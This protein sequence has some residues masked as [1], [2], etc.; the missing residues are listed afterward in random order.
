MAGHALILVENLSVP[1][2]RRVWQECLALREAGWRGHVICPQGDQAGHRALRRDRRR[3]DP[4]L[5]AH[6][7]PSAGRSGTSGSTPPRCGT[8][9]GWPAKVGRVDVVHACNP[10]DL[11]YLVAKQL[12]RRGARF[13]FDQHDLVPELYLSRFDRGKDLL[14]R[15]GLPDGAQDLRGGRR[16][17]RDQR[18]ATGRPRS[19]AVASARR[20]SSWSAARRSWSGSARCR[21]TR[22]CGRGK[23]YLL[24]LPRASWV[25][26]DG[27]DY[28]LRAL[29]KLRDEVGRSDWHAVFIGGGD[30][31][32][33]HGRALAASWACPTRWSSPAGSRTRT[34]CGICPPRT[35]A[36]RPIRSTRSTTCRP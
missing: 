10:P 7:R 24:C 21:R 3:P 25:P 26:Q 5:P 17:H 36:S 28:A 1:F 16:G 14:Y 22:R 4:P 13:V 23:P 8:P 27:V 34:C 2:D 11:L 15:A 30:T 12:K 33:R 9:G 35:S 29:T 18:V 31:L 6:A 19:P 32:R 20:T